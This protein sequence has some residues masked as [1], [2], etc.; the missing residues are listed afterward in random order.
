MPQA[1][2]LVVGGTWH[3][4][5]KRATGE[6]EG[7]GEALD[8]PRATARAR[9]ETSRSRVRLAVPVGDRAALGRLLG[10]VELPPARDP[11]EHR[12]GEPVKVRV[13][14]AEAAAQ[15]LGQLLVA[16]E[17]VRVL[18]RVELDLRLSTRR[19]R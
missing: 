16:G 10:R 17:D 4:Q 14:V 5:G 1:G 7:A 15:L 2:P 11:R 6:R 9:A 19:E 8:A 12:V 18:D 13:Q 3:D